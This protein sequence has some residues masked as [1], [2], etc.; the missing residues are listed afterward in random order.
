MAPTTLDP[1]VTLGIRAEAS[2]DEAVHAHRRLAMQFH[3]D[4][5]PGPGVAERMRRITEAWRVLSDP[6]GAGG[7]TPNAM[8]NIGRPPITAPDPAP[9]RGPLRGLRAADEYRDVD[10]LAG[11]APLRDA[12]HP[13]PRPNPVEPSFGDRPA[14]FVAV[15]VVLALLF[16]IG[17]W[18]GSLSP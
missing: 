16:F 13:P 12:P 10:D 7:M 14:L 8:L 15:W 1:Y 6:P 2:R 4:V 5:N 18:L 9:P 11:V 3:P 17:T